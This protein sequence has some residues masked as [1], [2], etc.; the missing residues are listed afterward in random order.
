MQPSGRNSSHRTLKATIAIL[1]LV[2][3]GGI[4]FAIIQRDP[5]FSSPTQPRRWAEAEF[6]ALTTML[7]S[8]PGKPTDPQYAVR[9]RP[10]VLAPL[11]DPAWGQQLTIEV[12]A[13]AE[14]YH[15]PY[16][17]IDFK[18][19]D[20]FTSADGAG[21]VSWLAARTY[22]PY[23]NLDQW[24]V[25]PLEMFHP[26]GDLMNA[27]D[28]DAMG[29]TGEKL[30]RHPVQGNPVLE[31]YMQLSGY[32]D[33]RWS[34]RQVFD[35]ATHVPLSQSVYLMNDV[36]TGVWFHADL[37]ILH[38]APLVAVFDLNHGEIREFP[39]KP[40]KG[41]A[42]EQSEF[43]F[44]VI[45]VI[46]APVIPQDSHNSGSGVATLRQFRWPKDNQKP[47]SSIIFQVNPP[48]MNDSVILEAFDTEGKRI[49]NSGQGG[50][51]IGYC[52]FNS[53]LEKI[54]SLR[55]R[56]RP[57]FTRLLLR[58]D[59]LP[60]V[61]PNNVKPANLFDVTVPVITF[62]DLNNMADFIS[63]TVQFKRIAATNRYGSEFPITLHNASPRQMI[64]R[65]IAMDPKRNKVI[66]DPVAKTIRFE[67]M[68]KR[69]ILDYARSM[70]NHAIGK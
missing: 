19:T 22:V 46:D 53:P 17:I 67:S 41:A 50:E 61:L 48:S 68:P 26:N 34:L 30:L 54:S 66:V 8:S 52:Y 27:H 63:E 10:P 57:H 69:S 7:V 20:G 3:T 23:V 58:I 21:K 40:M 12:Q 24:N 13:A 59:A 38:D 36:R 65:Y 31:V 18:A 42:V 5:F 15:P 11:P 43:K 45:E 55:V 33:A 56:F 4:F 47:S 51:D 35:S 44:E 28:A 29:M 49:Q 60:A 9:C 25:P 14:P 6:Q 2:S 70:L 16:R 64:E 39:C 37:N 62:G 1:A 32:Q